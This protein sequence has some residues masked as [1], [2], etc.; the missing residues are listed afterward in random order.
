MRVWQCQDCG[1]KITTRL[2][3][4]EVCECG[5]KNFELVE[6]KDRCEMCGND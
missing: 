1:I 2:S 6:K 4:P 5:G 3:S